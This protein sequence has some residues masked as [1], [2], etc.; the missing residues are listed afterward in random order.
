MMKRKYFSTK[1]LP[2]DNLRMQGRIVQLG[3]GGGEGEWR[4]C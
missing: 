2:S 3:C 4:T 1:N